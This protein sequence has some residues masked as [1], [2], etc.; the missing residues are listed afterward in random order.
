MKKLIVFFDKTNEPLE[1]D[2][3]NPSFFLYDAEHSVTKG[4]RDFKVL[5]KG[6]KLKCLD[7]FLECANAGTELNFLGATPLSYSEVIN[8][9]NS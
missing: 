3:L 1:F 2:E 8:L 6:K 5:S 9:V 4:K 7:K